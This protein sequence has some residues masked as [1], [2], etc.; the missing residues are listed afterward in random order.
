[1]TIPVAVATSGMS[2]FV[3]PGACGRV[4]GRFRD[5]LSRAGLAIAFEWQSAEQ[6]RRLCGIHLSPS[7]A[8]G[9]ISPVAAL[10]GAVLNPEAMFESVMRVVLV[11]KLGQTHFFCLRGGADAEE[12][13]RRLE[14]AIY[15][16][17][18]RATASHSL[19]FNGH[20]PDQE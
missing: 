4:A 7:L 16:T 20:R 15:A 12:Q 10:R 11:E 19:T 18:G 13:I 5:E 14:E 3:A 2:V 1:M 8:F 6:L 17:G 9:I